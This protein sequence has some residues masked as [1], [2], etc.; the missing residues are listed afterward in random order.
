MSSSLSL[1]DLKYQ[2]QVLLLRCSVLFTVGSLSLLCLLVVSWFVCFF[3]GWC[4][5]G[6]GVFHAG[7]VS[8]CLGPRLGWGGVGAPLG[9][10]GPSGGVF[11]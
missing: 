8:V 11:Y 1:P 2:W 4:I 9:R 5:G 3:F 10:F 7:Q 6:L